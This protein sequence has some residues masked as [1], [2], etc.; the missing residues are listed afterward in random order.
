[1]LHEMPT[2]EEGRR[3]AAERDAEIATGRLGVSKERAQVSHG[4]EDELSAY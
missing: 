4:T 2:G 3:R 1:M